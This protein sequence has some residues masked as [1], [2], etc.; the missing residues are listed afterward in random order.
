[1]RN[2]SWNFRFLLGLAAAGALL[3]ASCQDIYDALSP[4]QESSGI[5]YVKVD[6]GEGSERTVRPA[7]IN[8]DGTID[9]TILVKLIYTF[10]KE[11]EEDGKEYAPD[12]STNLFAIP[13]GR[14][15]VNVKA[16]QTWVGADDPGNKLAASGTS[17]VFSITPDIVTTVRLGLA[18][19]GDDK[20]YFKFSI[21]YPGGSTATAVYTLDKWVDGRKVAQDIRTSPNIVTV[22]TG[23]TNNASPNTANSGSGLVLDVGSYVFT[24]TV[25]LDDGTRY[26]GFTEVIHIYPNLTTDFGSFIFNSANMAA[27]TDSAEAIRLLKEGIVSWIAVNTLAPS[28]PS[29]VIAAS[30]S[31]ATAQ[32]EKLRLYYLGENFASNDFSPRVIALQGG[33]QLDTSIT[34]DW[35]LPNKTDPYEV[36]LKNINPALNDAN[37]DPLRYILVLYPVAEYN[38]TRRPSAGNVAFANLQNTIVETVNANTYLGKVGISTTLN[39]T[40]AD[41]TIDNIYTDID[42][43]SVNPS[44]TSGTATFTSRSKTYAIDV[45][46]PE[47]TQL[48][49]AFIVLKR[50]IVSWVKEVNPD[51]LATTT[52]LNRHVR[53]VVTASGPTEG[54]EVGIDLYYLG[55]KFTGLVFPITLKGGQYGGVWVNKSPDWT[56]TDKTSVVDKP[57]AFQYTTGR[58]SYTINLYMNPV[59]EFVVSYDSSIGAD[60]A[61][62]RNVSFNVIQAVDGVD[63]TFVVK[64]IARGDTTNPNAASARAIIA[65]GGVEKDPVGTPGT[66]TLEITGTGTLFTITNSTSTDITSGTIAS[67][68]GTTPAGGT[69]I[70]GLASKNVYSLPLTLPSD[71][72]T[73]K[74]YK[75]GSEQKA[76]AKTAIRNLSHQNWSGLYTLDST[77]PSATS[78]NK[79]L[80]TPSIEK[81]LNAN[82]PTT[83]TPT[84]VARDPDF[85][86]VYY[87]DTTPPTIAFPT[88]PTLPTLPNDENRPFATGHKYTLSNASTNTVSVQYTPIGGRSSAAITDIGTIYTIYTKAVV[89]YSVNYVDGSEVYT[90]TSGADPAP[91]TT[92]FVYIKDGTNAETT[93]QKAGNNSSGWKLLGIGDPNLATV[94]GV[95]GDG[96]ITAKKD[97]AAFAFGTIAGT[98]NAAN[99]RN[100]FTATAVNLSTA[101]L[102]ELTVYPSIAE[103]EAKAFSEWSKVSPISGGFATLATSTAWASN[104]DFDIVTNS[105]NNTSA[106]KLYYLENTGSAAPGFAL[107]ATGYFA[108]IN[109]TSTSGTDK[110]WSI[111]ATAGGDV[112]FAAVGKDTASAIK[113]GTITSEKVVQFRVVFDNSVT[114]TDKPIILSDGTTTYNILLNTPQK[115]QHFSGLGVAATAKV[116]I[117]SLDFA[118]TYAT[119]ANPSGTANSTLTSGGEYAY[120]YDGSSIAIASQENIITVYNKKEVQRKAALTNLINNIGVWTRDGRNSSYPFYNYST[121]ADIGT[122]NE[123]LVTNIYYVWAATPSAWT[124][125]GNAGTA[126]SPNTLANSGWALASGTDNW[127]V[128]SAPTT[129]NVN[130]VKVVNLSYAYKGVSDSVSYKVN[131]IAVADYEVEF[132]LGAQGSVTVSD[133]DGSLS[134]LVDK[135]KLISRI[136]PVSFLPSNSRSFIRLVDMTSPPGTTIATGNPGA[137]LVQSVTSK[138]Y[139]IQLITEQN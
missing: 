112:K 58:E 118:F 35:T 135:E 127:N 62:G 59:A 122:A 17:D 30:G 139:K 55:T 75:S 3:L 66:F 69:L 19:D 138:K 99:G 97:S 29:K 110:K 51:V 5:G 124:T 91:N 38:I 81:Y 40:N 113:I 65:Y 12:G 133:I 54:Q 57:I 34:A 85:S 18:P 88:Y 93:Y 28:L 119:S 129:V 126:S 31:G 16:Y 76:D 84:L 73:V 39:V 86:V 83:T 43:D 114:V 70:S 134:G 49:D 111:A 8:S 20:G 132:V 10:I 71:L 90:D 104:P 50:D 27:I 22:T 98:P 37:G 25:A 46:V 106:V 82:P 9:D 21:T 44:L 33:W 120:T 45:H 117:S 109:P 103:Q 77:D 52:L 56:I 116:K 123:N 115:I 15:S 100:E 7:G 1:M 6:I 128:P 68:D 63:A 108:E 67:D 89:Q 80:A 36:T 101:G 125:S 60:A 42:R 48:A 94:I 64:N 79:K 96:I 4:P 41:I 102:L 121:V 131:L 137:A 72:Y 130:D 136:G 92:R 32:P 107:P 13:V 87:F 78:I 24:F 26:G 74:V 53:P 95:K 11:G 2:K 14:Y 61:A 105:T 23:T 47:A